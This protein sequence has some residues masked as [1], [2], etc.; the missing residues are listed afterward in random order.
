L[1]SDMRRFSKQPVIRR[2]N[3]LAPDYADAMFNLAVH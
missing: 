2:T 3:E 1:A